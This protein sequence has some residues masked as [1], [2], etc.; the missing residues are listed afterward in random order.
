VPATTKAQT[1]LA[2]HLEKRGKVQGRQ[3]AQALAEQSTAFNDR[4]IELFTRMQ[5]LKGS[6]APLMAKELQAPRDASE[7]RALRRLTR[8]LDAV[9]TDIVQTNYG[10][11]RG[12]VR[13]FTS[14]TSAEDSQDFENA[15]VVGLMRAIATYDLNKGKFGQWAFKPIQREVLRAVRD[16]DHP[17]MNPGD[18]EKRAD[19]L[20]AVRKLVKDNGDDYKYTHVEVAEL[21]GTSL[22]QVGRVLNAP[23]LDSLATPVGD[24]AGTTLGDLIEDTHEDLEDAVMARISITALENFGLVVLDARE[25]FVIV[26]RFGLDGEPRQRLSAIGEI[27]GLSREAVRQVEAKAIAK[28]QHP[29]VLRNLNNAGRA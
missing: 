21:S 20:K 25:L 15:G 22:E 19:I 8:Q 6:I 28:I 10:L 17:N 23:R 4:N 16:A 5:E 2:E 1:A 26:R 29:T 27:L 3:S 24:A 11:V 18:F 14:N 13:R 9:M 7:I 12:Y